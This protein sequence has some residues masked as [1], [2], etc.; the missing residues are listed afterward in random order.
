MYPGEIVTTLEAIRARQYRQK[1]RQ[2]AFIRDI[3]FGYSSSQ[4]VTA[5]KKEFIR[6]EIEISKGFTSAREIALEVR[7]VFSVKLG[8]S[9]I[10]NYRKKMG[11]VYRRARAMPN[12]SFAKKKQRELFAKR[13]KQKT[14]KPSCVGVREKSSLKIN[15]WAAIRSKGP[16]RF[17]SFIHQIVTIIVTIQAVVTKRPLT[18]YNV[19]HRYGRISI[20][21]TQN[22]EGP[23]KLPATQIFS[24]RGFFSLF[25]TQ[26][27]FAT[28]LQTYFVS[29]LN[30][31][32]T[33][34]LI[35]PL[36]YLQTV[37]SL[38]DNDCVRFLYIALTSVSRCRIGFNWGL[39]VSDFYFHSV[40]ILIV[41]S[42]ASFVWYKKRIA[43]K[44][45]SNFGWVVGKVVISFDINVF[46]TWILFSVNILN[47]KMCCG[48]VR[49]LFLTFLI[50]KRL[51]AVFNASC[52]SFVRDCTQIFC[53][54]MGVFLSCFRSK[55][56]SKFL[57]INIFKIF[58]DSCYVFESC[59]Y[60]AV[61]TDRVREN[62]EF[63]Y[64]F[65]HVL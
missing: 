64:V 58:W 8:L 39:T 22:F 1:K 55:S 49:T 13:Y 30:S 16:S 34:A 63:F 60:W 19:V 32:C 25:P 44:K 4:T 37:F 17:Y 54:E 46:L 41:L 6:N 14:S 59:C 11:Y 35:L 53:I 9:I 3:S 62:I 51:V 20:N 47:F 28:R 12:L 48:I 31:F 27:G 57:P 40:R 29:F 43:S 36:R 23:S 38:T 50:W 56:F 18:L 61:I 5:V 24:F 26:I 33:F 65:Q 2:N 52:I 10:C 21:L 7:R 42:M 45:F 15:I